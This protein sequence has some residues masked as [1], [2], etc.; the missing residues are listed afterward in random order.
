MIKLLAIAPHTDIGDICTG[1]YL[2]LRAGSCLRHKYVHHAS[3]LQKFIVKPDVM[4][5]N[6][7]ALKMG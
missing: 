1:K 2:L 4:Y 6:Q 3:K 5:T 7:R